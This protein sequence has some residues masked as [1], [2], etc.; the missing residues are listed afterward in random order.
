MDERMKRATHVRGRCR[1]ATNKEDPACVTAWMDPEGLMLSEVSQRKANIIR[2][3]L[4]VKSGEKKKRTNPN[5]NSIVP[6]VTMKPG[7]ADLG[8][9]RM[10]E[11]GVGAWGHHLSDAEAMETVFIKYL[12][13]RLW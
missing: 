4:L 6:G 7:E 3:H 11:P 9:W 8:L 1:S 13:Y 5:K 10:E 2:S 12:Y